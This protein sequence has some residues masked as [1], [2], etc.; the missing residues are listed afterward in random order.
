MSKIQGVEYVTYEEAFAYF[1]AR[2]YSP[3]SASFLASRSVSDEDFRL[4]KS[5][6]YVTKVS[7]DSPVSPNR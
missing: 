4:N 3:Q 6:V 7:S 1:M 5:D 2:G